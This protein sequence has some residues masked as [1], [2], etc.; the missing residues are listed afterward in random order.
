VRSLASIAEAIEVGDGDSKMSSTSAKIVSA[1]AATANLGMLSIL[2]VPLT[3][4]P[5]RCLAAVGE[6]E[7]GNT[8]KNEKTHA[9]LL[10]DERL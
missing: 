4:R 1:P 9:T 5:P 6:M 7:I 8:K 10:I 2:R 3:P